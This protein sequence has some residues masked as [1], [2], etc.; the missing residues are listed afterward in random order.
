MSNLPA[1]NKK[2]GAPPGVRRGKLWDRDLSRVKHGA[3]THVGTGAGGG[4]KE[5]PPQAVERGGVWKRAK[6][7][8]F[9]GPRRRRTEP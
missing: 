6:A 5:T 9:S 8:H 3:G 2:Y 4:G 1:N 7:P